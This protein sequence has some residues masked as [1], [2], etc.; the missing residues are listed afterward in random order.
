MGASMYGIKKYSEKSSIDL[1]AGDGEMRCVKDEICRGRVL[2]V[3]LTLE[4]FRG[5]TLQIIRRPFLRERNTNKLC[6]VVR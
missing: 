5:I 2:M 4:S 6:S 3:L 1:V